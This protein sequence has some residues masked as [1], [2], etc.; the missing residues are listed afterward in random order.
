MLVQA[1]DTQHVFQIKL[2]DAFPFLRC[3]AMRVL[4]L[5]YKARRCGCV[6]AGPATPVG[7]KYVTS[8]CALDISAAS[9]QRWLEKKANHR[10]VC[11]CVERSHWKPFAI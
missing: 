1:H 6:T 4:M 3:N 5:V 9:L 7:Q 10:F 2:R 11:A 8:L